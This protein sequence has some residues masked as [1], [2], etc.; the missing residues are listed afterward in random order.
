MIERVS[1]AITKFQ[2]VTGDIPTHM[3]MNVSDLL[4]L[5]SE[6][7]KLGAHAAISP[8]MPEQGYAGVYRGVQIAISES[9]RP[10]EM[11]IGRMLRMEL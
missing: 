9:L 3:D 1:E 10:G 4:M 2:Q 6:L 11:R 5:K 8:M 7:S